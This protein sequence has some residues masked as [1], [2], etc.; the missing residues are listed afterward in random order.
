MGGRLPSES[1]AGLR[2]NQWPLSVGLRK[3]IVVRRTPNIAPRSDCVR[4]SRPE[5]LAAFLQL[6]RQMSVLLN[7]GKNVSR[8]GE[9]SAL[10]LSS[11]AIQLVFLHY[12]LVRLA[13]V[14]DPILE[15]VAFGRQE[16][17]DRIEASGFL[18]AK[19]TYE[20]ADLK[21]VI[22]HASVSPFLR[23]PPRSRPSHFAPSFPLRRKST[24]VG[25][26]LGASYVQGRICN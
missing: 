8:E 21:F 13:G 5:P 6:T 17:S 24:R 9:G 15:I 10:I 20:L 25:I 26:S 4:C 14:S 12:S 16:L 2:R 23:S 7:R 11:G 1:V 18:T 19:I 3:V 22:T